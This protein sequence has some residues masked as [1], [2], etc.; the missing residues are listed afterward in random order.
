MATFYTAFSNLIKSI[1][2]LNILMTGG[3]WYR[4][5]PSDDDGNIDW[6]YNYLAWDIALKKIDS[7][8]VGT[9]AFKTYNVLI[10]VMT[11]DGDDQLDAI[12]ELIVDNLS[13][14]SD[15]NIH[16]LQF[17]S[18]NKYTKLDEGE[19]GVYFSELTFTGIF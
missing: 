4:N 18:E 14:Y 3:I 5:I 17:E 10:V 19:A 9:A 1:P 15:D 7:C 6:T 16:F 2:T 8:L 11:D 12:V 13:G